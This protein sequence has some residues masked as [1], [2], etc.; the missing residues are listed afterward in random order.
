MKDPLEIAKLLFCIIV[1]AVLALLI[2][3]E[4][5]VR[6]NVSGTITYEDLIA[7]ILTSLG[8]LLAALAVFLGVFALYSWRNF[9]S[10]VKNHVEDYLNEFVKP[11]ER[12]EAISALLEDHKEKTKRL[13]EVEKE[14]ENLSNFD[15][16]EV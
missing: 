12:Y 5:E 11:T 1:G 8:V 16:D 9:N 13:A 14:L 3:H 15:E 10:R 6:L 4:N 2:F 7:L